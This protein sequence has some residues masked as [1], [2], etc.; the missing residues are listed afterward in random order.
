M[1]MKKMKINSR[2]LQ[3]RDGAD[4][5]MRQRDRKWIMKTLPKTREERIRED[6]RSAVTS[7]KSRQ[8]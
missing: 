2:E 4:T 8:G 6:I 7:G 5:L 1:P 3:A